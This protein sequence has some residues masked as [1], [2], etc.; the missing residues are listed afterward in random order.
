MTADPAGARR[1]RQ[2]AHD[3]R[4]PLSVVISYSTLLT[5]GSLGPLTDEQRSALADVLRCG[6]EMAALVDA[7]S[8]AAETLDAT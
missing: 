2:L 5:E 8:E 6:Q 3:L 4:G 1:L 7:L